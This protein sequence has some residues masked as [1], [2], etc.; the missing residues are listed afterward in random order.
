MITVTNHIPD[1]SLV[2]FVSLVSVYN[3]TGGAGTSV[4]P[5]FPDGF[6]GVIYQDAG[7]RMTLGEG[8]KK[9]SK[10]FVY[11]QTVEPLEL[12][13]TGEC[14]LIIFQLYPEIPNYLFDINARA[15][16][17]DCADL[18]GDPDVCNTGLL[19]RL[20]GVPEDG[21]LRLM[22]RYIR[23]AMRRSTRKESSRIGLAVRSIIDEKGLISIS[24]L[25]ENLFMSERSFER[26]FMQEIGISPKLFARIIQFRF[27][28]QQITLDAGRQLTD[29]GYENGFADQ[30]HFIRS[31]KQFS[32]K[33]PRVFRRS[34]RTCLNQ[35]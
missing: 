18:T 20:E 27:S 34:A 24:R 3:V 2:G 28:M 4:L 31:F 19:A 15:L 32:G 1:K 29:V 10:L 33:T 9:L 5:C 21:Q 26:K 14:R 25:R 16:N 17:N 7:S 6:P 35:F 11:G 22:S 13:V 23:Q 8:G 12:V 30:S